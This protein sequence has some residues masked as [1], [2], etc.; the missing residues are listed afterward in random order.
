VSYPPQPPHDPDQ[1]ENGEPFRLD[2]VM[3]ES[4][5]PPRKRAAWPAAALVVAVV[6]CGGAAWIAYDRG[7]ILK[8]SG[9]EACEAMRD[10][11]KTFA[12]KTADDK[13]MTE[14]EY[15]KV[16]AVF[17]DSRHDDIR[18]HGT[19]LMD[20]AWQISKLGD[21]PGLEALPYVGPLTEHMTGLQSACADQG[22]IVS[23]Q[24]ATPAPSGAAKPN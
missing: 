1:P 4:A 19:K 16:R 17:E 11:D 14:A 24:N 20:L 6:V 10:G 23:L 5:S 21:N 9:I 12:G 3:P 7:V 18:D 2:Q 22:V 8:D 13:T 15:R